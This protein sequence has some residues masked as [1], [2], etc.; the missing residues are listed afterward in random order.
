MPAVAEGFDA[1]ADTGCHASP[2][3]RRDALVSAAQR[4]DVA[5]RDRL[6]ASRLG[7]VRAVAEH[8]RHMGLALDD[9]VQEGSL[10]LLEAI[11]RYDPGRGIDFD[12]YARFRIRRSIRNALTEQGRLIRLP[13]HVVERQRL[14][15]RTRDAW[16]ASCGR[17]PTVEELASATGLSTVAIDEVL[18]APG[19]AVSL[20]GCSAAGVPYADLIADAGALDPESVAI[21][22]EQAR[23]LEEAVESLPPRRRLVVE[24]A[25]GLD[26]PATPTPTI[27]AELAVTPAR[28]R[29]IARDSLHELRTRLTTAA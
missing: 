21:A 28:T 4:G 1:T 3:P 6:V 8:Y 23:R 12:A 18:A 25:F 29:A 2:L 15:A 7:L 26:G 16:L 27:A 13:K 14:V 24:R 10:G 22:H 11:E 20:D 9:L 5:A 17:S 19:G